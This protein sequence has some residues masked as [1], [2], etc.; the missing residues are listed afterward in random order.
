MASIDN[1]KKNTQLFRVFFQ[2]FTSTELDIF[3]FIITQANL[4]NTHIC[5][6]CGMT[7]L[8]YLQAGSI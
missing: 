1:N 8:L 2:P 3:F 4:L 5:I 7:N 6:Y